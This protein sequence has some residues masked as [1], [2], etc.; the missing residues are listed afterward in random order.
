MSWRQI[1][2]CQLFDAW[3]ASPTAA[4]LLTLHDSKV[5]EELSPKLCSSG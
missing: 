4:E 1:A 2:G 3:T 5:V